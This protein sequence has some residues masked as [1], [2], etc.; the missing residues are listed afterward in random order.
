MAVFWTGTTETVPATRSHH[1][2]QRY[3]SYRPHSLIMRG[4]DSH[5]FKRRHSSS[6]PV[7]RLLQRRPRT[8]SIH[9]TA[10]DFKASIHNNPY[11][12]NRCRTLKSQTANLKQKL[13]ELIASVDELQPDY[14]AMDW[15]ASAGTVIYVP[16]PVASDNEASTNSSG[17]SRSQT[18]G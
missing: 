3:R 12:T 18:S 4:N 14:W 11:L 13:E 8:Q 2:P 1:L 15:A 17:T 9:R 10:T 5:I 7:P 6:M 16:Y